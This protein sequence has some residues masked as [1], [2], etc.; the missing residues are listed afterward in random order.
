MVETIA[1]EQIAQSVV[2][3]LVTSDSGQMEVRGFGV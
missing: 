1:Q 2:S 3:H